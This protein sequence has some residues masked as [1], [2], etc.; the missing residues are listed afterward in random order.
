MLKIRG[1]APLSSGDVISRVLTFKGAGAS[2]DNTKI[3]LHFNI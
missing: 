3:K 1:C 2:I